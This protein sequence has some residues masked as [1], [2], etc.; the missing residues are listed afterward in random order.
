M[1]L[2]QQ[3][4]QDLLAAIQSIHAI[5][6]LETF[7]YQVLSIIP[8]VVGSDLTTFCQINFQKHRVLWICPEFNFY[9][10]IDQT[11][12]QYLPTQHFN[13][14]PL[15]SNFP[16]QQAPLTS[17]VSDFLTEPQ[18]HRLGTFYEQFLQPAGLADQMG[19][20]LMGVTQK[21]AH[22]NH[23]SD[24]QQDFLGL[25]IHRD[26][27]NFTETDRYLLNLLRPHLIQAYRNLNTL[28]QLK[29]ESQGLRD[30]LDQLCVIFLTETGKPQW[31][32]QAV[33]DLF[34]KY[35]QISPHPSIELPFYIQQW[36]KYQLATE[37]SEPLHLEPYPPLRLELEE[38]CLIL[39]LKCDPQKAQNLLFLEE[40][41]K[42]TLSLESLEYLGLTRREAEVF[43]HIS[44]G[45]KNQEVAH[46]L[47]ITSG[48][49]RNHLERIFAKLGVQNRSA[50]VNVALKKLGLLD[51]ETSALC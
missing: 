10:K 27:R 1:D 22:L 11:D 47:G 26:R 50:A 23:L 12:F 41:R 33:V 35:G 7:P 31:I 30:A 32:S 8:R 17:K 38:S 28:V 29:L 5:A 15:L 25:A 16:Q 3:E 18:L 14:N 45:K 34:Q 39:R 42:F 13:E 20:P 51:T 43:S 48:T 36:I 6:D 21:S 9:P 37:K 4:L 49:V 44:D 19:V 24:T 40:Q 46:L 2:T